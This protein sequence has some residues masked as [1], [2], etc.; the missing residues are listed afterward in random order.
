MDIG[1]GKPLP[2]SPDELVHK[3][4]IC[5]PT[6]PRTAYAKIQFVFQQPLVLQKGVRL[7]PVNPLGWEYPVATCISSA[8]KDHGQLPLRVNTSTNS[9][10]NKFGD[11]YEDSP[12]S[13]IPNSED[14]PYI[15]TKN[16]ISFSFFV[17]GILFALD[18]DYLFSIGHNDIVDIVAI[19]R[20]GQ[21][22]IDRILISYTQENALRFTKESGVILNCLSFCRCIYYTKHLFQ[23]CLEKLR[24]RWVSIE[25]LHI[26]KSAEVTDI[27]VVYRSGHQESS[28]L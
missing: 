1:F 28:T 13:L 18:G 8:I 22:L 7:A 4:I 9:C 24:E 27:Q 11:G 26:I 21:A 2:R 6:N 15:Y 12:N 10:Q 25:I 5:L 19:S 16:T 23:M 17:T 3:A 20:L 14:L